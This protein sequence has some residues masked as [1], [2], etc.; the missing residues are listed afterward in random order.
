MNRRA[1]SALTR[2]GGRPIL[3]PPRELRPGWTAGADGSPIGHGRRDTIVEPAR[4]RERSRSTHPSTPP[5]RG[6]LRAVARRLHPNA[7]LLGPPA[8]VRGAAI[9]DGATSPGAGVRGSA[10][11]T[12]PRRGSSSQKAPD[13]PGRARDRRRTLHRGAEDGPY[14]DVLELL[15]ADLRRRL[16][17]VRA[18]DP[19]GD[20][21]RRLG[22]RDRPARPVPPDPQGGDPAAR[23]PGAGVRRW[24]PGIAAGR[25]RRLP[26]RLARLRRLV[27]APVVGAR[28]RRDRP[29]RRLR[30]RHPR[31]W[32]RG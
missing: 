6:P 2:I 12:P 23:R 7:T 27:V 8:P 17:G 20:A 15:P 3:G 4:A 18:G 9:P 22:R 21:D 1:E 13:R 26:R 10:G 28:R 14:H 25:V 16:H 29:G 19:A 32:A 5:G 31:A 30:R 24:P 11:G